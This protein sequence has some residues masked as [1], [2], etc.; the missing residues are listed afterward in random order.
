[1]LLLLMSGACDEKKHF[2]LLN[3]ITCCRCYDASKMY[4]LSSLFGRYC[5]VYW[6]WLKAVFPL[7]LY[8]CSALSCVAMYCTDIIVAGQASDAEIVVAEDE[9]QDHLEVVVIAPSTWTAV[10]SFCFTETMQ[11]SNSSA[12]LCLICFVFCTSSSCTARCSQSTVFRMYYTPLRGENCGARSRHTCATGL[13][14]TFNSVPL[15]YC[16]VLHFTVLYSLLGNHCF[17][18]RFTNV[19]SSWFCIAMYCTVNSQWW[20]CCWSGFRCQ[21]RGRWGRAS[22]PTMDWFWKWS[23][24]LHLHELLC[25]LFA[26]LKKCRNRIPVLHSV[27]FCFVFCTSSSCTARCP[28]SPIFRMYCTPLRGEN[29]GAGSRHTCATGLGDAF[30]SVPLCFLLFQQHGECLFEQCQ[31]VEPSRAF[32]STISIEQCAKTLQVD[33]EVDKPSKG[34]HI[35]R[36]WLTKIL[37]N[38]KTWELRGDATKTR[39]LIGLQSICEHCNTFVVFCFGCQNMDPG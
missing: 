29:C 25:F 9:L 5:T 34:L 7:A 15:D 14:N 17:L 16:H 6:Y 27:W 19:Y 12:I 20:H 30:N 21:D 22:G 33:N 37:E 2:G 28:Q 23:S 26:L 38:G 10:F 18:W 13:G 32:L 4:V 3:S 39:G 8:E 1:M 24:L 11:K 36:C 35:D 31:L